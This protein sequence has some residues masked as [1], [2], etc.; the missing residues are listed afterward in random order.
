MLYYKTYK[1]NASDPWVVFIHGAG[2]S[3]SIWYKQLRAY[4]E[5]FNILLVDLRGHGRSQE[6]LEKHL[7]QDY[8]FDDI[9]KDV[10]D[11]LV[12]AKIEKAHFVGISLGT[13]VVR[14]IGELAPERVASMVLGGAIVRLNFRHKF[15][16]AM[17]HTFKRFI[18]FIFLY[19]FFAWVIMPR[20]RHSES[21]ILFIR[22]AQRLARKEFL[23]WWK[24]THEVNPLLRYFKEKEL[25]T[26][27]LYLMG[28]EDYMFLAPVRKLVNEHKHALLKVVEKCGHVVNV[29]KPEE[30]NQISIDF[31]SKKSMV[32]G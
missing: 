4:R 22:E 5:V 24:L 1:R 23:R 29:E 6:F 17:G 19:K 13:I 2:G 26:P 9:A 31:I 25:A 21:R 16:V 10:I 30:F 18:P 11:V 32:L 20:K 28:E 15:F 14:T 8:T 12:D 27:T 3:S 7:K